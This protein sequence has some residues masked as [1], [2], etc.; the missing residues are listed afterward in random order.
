M[1]T[2]LPLDFDIFE[3]SKSCQPCAVTALGTHC[4]DHA[5]CSSGGSTGDFSS[6]LC[7]SF[8]FRAIRNAGQ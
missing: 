4:S 7:C 1:R 3:S 2:I 8:G 6:L 5:L